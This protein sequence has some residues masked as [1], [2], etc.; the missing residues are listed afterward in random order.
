MDERFSLCD[1][2]TVPAGGAG[3][4]LFESEFYKSDCR[5]NVAAWYPAS[6]NSGPGKRTVIWLQGCRK[7]CEGC[8][9]PHLHSFTDRE[10]VEVADL[11][12]LLLAIKGIEGITVFGGEPLLQ[13]RALAPLLG[14]VKAGGLTV[15]LYT[16]FLYEEL[17]AAAAS[18][19][20][21][22]E[23]LAATD[24]LVDGPY[25]VTED[26]NEMWRGSAN[27]RILFLSDAYRHYAWVESA[28]NRDMAFHYSQDGGYIWLGIQPRRHQI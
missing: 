15:M 19:G 7:R 25:I 22:A 28:H 18:Y 10:W 17:Q 5:L 24:I 23:I 3:N 16:G 4:H 26:H 20:A 12:A 13:Y 11:A 27:Q 9:N 2:L 8:V 6:E 1:Y 21:M 14:A